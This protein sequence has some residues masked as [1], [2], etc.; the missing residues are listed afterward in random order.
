MDVGG[1]QEL[2]LLTFQTLQLSL[3]DEAAFCGLVLGEA[4]WTADGLALRKG[5]G[6]PAAVS[7]VLKGEV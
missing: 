3:R 1:T 5:K 4:I 2:I 6:G 7:N